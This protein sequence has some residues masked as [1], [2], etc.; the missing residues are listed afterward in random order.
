MSDSYIFTTL[1]NNVQDTYQRDSIHYRERE[2]RQKYSMNEMVIKIL[3]R[4][5]NKMPKNTLISLWCTV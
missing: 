1:Y 4:C 2:I 3:S 5:Y